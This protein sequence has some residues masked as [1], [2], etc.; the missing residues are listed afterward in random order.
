VIG[1]EGTDEVNIFQGRVGLQ[2]SVSLQ[3]V[4]R[5]NNKGDVGI[6]IIYERPPVRN[7][8]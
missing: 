2:Y 4:W 8:I 7:C 5:T 3:F 1:F 6:D